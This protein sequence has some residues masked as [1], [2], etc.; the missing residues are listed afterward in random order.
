MLNTMNAMNGVNSS[1]FCIHI[2]FGRTSDDNDADDKFQ[3]DWP[4]VSNE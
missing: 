3:C 2:E 4:V 1:S